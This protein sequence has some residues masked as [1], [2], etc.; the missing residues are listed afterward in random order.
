MAGGGRSYPA[1]CGVI[2]RVSVF[3]VHR[4]KRDRNQR[5]LAKGYH[6]PAPGHHIPSVLTGHMVYT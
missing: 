6:A 3:L 4:R 1:T 2:F 5:L